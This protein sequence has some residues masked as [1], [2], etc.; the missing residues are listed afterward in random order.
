MGQERGHNDPGFLGSELLL[1]PFF[2]CLECLSPVLRLLGSPLVLCWVCSYRRA[3]DTGDLWGSK[4]AT[5]ELPGQKRLD[6]DPV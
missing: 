6:A 5:T 4:R 1:S 2:L 3:L